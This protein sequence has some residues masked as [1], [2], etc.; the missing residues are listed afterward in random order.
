[1]LALSV[2][3]ITRIVFPA[4]LFAALLSAALPATPCRGSDR[5]A[6]DPAITLD[7]Q[8]EPLRNVLGRISKATRWKITVPDKWMDRPITQRLN[9]VSMEEGLRF[10]LKD[11]GIENLL[12]T[13]DEG[14]KTVTVYDTEIQPGQAAIGGAR[15][16]V[17]SAGSQPDAVLKRPAGDEGDGPSRGIRRAR[18][19]RQPRTEEE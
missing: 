11:A 19:R 9:R 10:I 3:L 1:M 14:R 13:Y 5:A 12:L 15:P 17:P 6:A 8:N 16:P 18:T 2:T 4:L 7:V